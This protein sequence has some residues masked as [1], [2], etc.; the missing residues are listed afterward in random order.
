MAKGGRSSSKKTDTNTESSTAATESRKKRDRERSKIYYA[1]KFSFPEVS[2]ELAVET[3]AAVKAKRRVSDAPRRAKLA[4]SKLAEAEL[5]ASEVLTKML[6]LKQAADESPEEDEPEEELS[7]WEVPG[8]EVWARWKTN[9]DTWEAECRARGDWFEEGEGNSDFEKRVADE[10]QANEIG[11]PL[12]AAT[13]ENNGPINFHRRR[14]SIR[15]PMP[16]SNSPSPQPQGR[17]PSFY[18]MLWNAVDK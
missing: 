2:L 11:N 1:N 9:R 10:R 7:N 8:P 5:A 14:H 6:E 15:L 4:A 17:L 12:R 18:D 13:G 16:V 3:R